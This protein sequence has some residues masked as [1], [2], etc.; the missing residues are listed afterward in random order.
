MKFLITTMQI[1][2][3]GGIIN[4]TEQLI[5]GLRELGHT[6]DLVQLVWTD[7]VL[8][9]K[10]SPNKDRYGPGAIYNVSQYEGW[11]W[12]EGKRIPY[13]GKRNIELW[14]RYAS[15]FDAV[16]HQIPVPTVR[17][18]NIGNLDWL[19]L[20]DT[21]T[22]NIGVIHDAWFQRRNPHLIAVSD[23]YD[24]VVCVHSAS[25]RNT[26]V[27]IPRVMILNPH[28]IPEDYREKC[29]PYNRRGKSFLSCHYWK[30]IKRMDGIVRAIPYIDMDI[31][32]IL[33]GTGIEYFYMN[34]KTGK[35]KYFNEVGVPIYDE[36]VE[37]GLDYVG[38]LSAEQ[39]S[40]KLGRVR[41]SVD[42]SWHEE[43]AKF[44]EV[45]LRSQIEAAVHGA[46]LCATNL[47]AAG[48]VEG[49]GEFWQAN[50][51]YVM[52]PYNCKPWEF[53]EYINHANNLSAREGLSLQEEAFKILPP[54]DRKTVAQQYVD[55]V[56]GTGGGY[57]DRVV[58]TK[59]LS[60]DVRLQAKK[61]IL[62]FEKGVGSGYGVQLED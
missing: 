7:H 11:L 40:S 53:A 57:Y 24:Y 54:W 37:Y 6:V 8:G 55:L 22:V 58:I 36:A 48:N 50:K 2:Q 44:G 29:I 59:K 12:P 20:Y 47:G 5:H 17:K 21:D 52:I 31:A 35:C 25:Y 30:K 10:R 42:P 49:S 16:I 18:D 4:H 26:K 46:V 28:Y 9:A 19:G 39:V 62:Y 45:W 51:N 13:K 34:S 41:T 56:D 32:K 14:R 1:Q 33:G 38:V 23:F 27:D 43:F 61:N 60:D 15:K 3:W